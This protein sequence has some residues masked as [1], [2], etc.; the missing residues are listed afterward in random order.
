VQFAER[1][2]RAL[3]PGIS[4]EEAALMP[5]A[6]KG[7]RRPSLGARYWGSEYRLGPDRVVLLPKD[8]PGL[9]KIVAEAVRPEDTP[10][11]IER[12][13]TLATGPGGDPVSYFEA[14]RSSSLS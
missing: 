2:N 13:R 4:V 3:P 10:M 5:A 8:G 6:P 9:K 7:T 1:M 11:R 14:F 12:L